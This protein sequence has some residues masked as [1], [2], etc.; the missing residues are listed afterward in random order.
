[1]ALVCGEHLKG[2]YGHMLSMGPCSS[3]PLACWRAPASRSQELGLSASAASLAL[4]EWLVCERSE[5]ERKRAILEEDGL[6]P[7]DSMALGARR[8]D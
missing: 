8:A 1:M 4:K 2:L 6:L 5:C 3:R 7:S